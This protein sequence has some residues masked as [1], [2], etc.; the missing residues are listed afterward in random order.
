MA[1]AIEGDYDES[2]AEEAAE[3]AVEA[4]PRLGR[5]VFLYREPRPGLDGL[6]YFGACASCQSFVPES[7]MS[8]AVMGDRCVKFG[9]S[10]PISD[11]DHCTLYEPWGSGIS[12]AAVTAFYAQELRKGVI[13]VS[14]WSVGYKSK[15]CV[16]C[17]TC[18]FFDAPGECEAMESLNEKSPNLFEL[19]TDVKP[20][21]WCSMWTAEPST[22]FPVMGVR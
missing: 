15:T 13:G 14:P 22:E 17:Q 1:T 16:Q 5:S 2:P 10:I 21:A 4:N 9:S 6:Q 18:C 19:A 12:C 20:R 11:D 3:P 8:G 7:E